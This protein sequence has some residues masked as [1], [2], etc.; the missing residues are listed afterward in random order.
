MFVLTGKLDQLRFHGRSASRL[1]ACQRFGTVEDPRDG[2]VIGLRDRVELVVVASS[3]G[4]RHSQKCA[5]RHIDL[6]IDH[7][8]L[9]LI[10]VAVDR[11]FGT[12]CQKARGD[13]QLI[14]F[15]RVLGRQHVTRQLFNN[16]FVVWLIRIERIDDIVSIPPGVPIGNVSFFSR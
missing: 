2:V 13:N 5:T 11:R 9:E 7:I 10:D 12:D 1:N 6:V 15:I 3:T 8:H 16:E 4:D 14:V